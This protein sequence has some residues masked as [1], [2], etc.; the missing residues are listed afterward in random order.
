MKHYFSDEVISASDELDQVFNKYTTVILLKKSVYTLPTSSTTTSLLDLSTPSQEKLPPVPMDLLEN[1]L[2]N[3]GFGPSTSNAPQ[4][5]SAGTHSPTVSPVGQSN[6]DVLGDIFSSMEP[7]QV[8]PAPVDRSIL[9]PV[10]VQSETNARIASNEHVEVHEKNSKL[11]A[12]DDL[13]S[14]G[15]SLLLQSLT[16]SCKLGSHFA[17]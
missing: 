3:L 8:A 4:A 7:I 10:N 6:Y 11:K 15:E 9:L 13:D 17:K 14:M 16:T 2:S 1:Q 12:L 5:S